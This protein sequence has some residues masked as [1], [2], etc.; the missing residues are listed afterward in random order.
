MQLDASE[1]QRCFKLK[2]KPVWPARA[3]WDLRVG[4]GA[5]RRYLLALFRPRLTRYFRY[6]HVSSA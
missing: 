6:A 3:E 5:N 1:N 2:S 4:M